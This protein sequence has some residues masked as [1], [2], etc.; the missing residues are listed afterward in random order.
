MPEQNRT[1]YSPFKEGK[2]FHIYNRANSS[3]DFL[4]YRSEN[5]TYFLKKYYEYLGSLLDTFAYCL[6][7]NHFHFM[8]RVGR[9]VNNKS[10]NTQDLITEQ[11]RRFFISYSQ[12]INKQESRRGSLFQKRFKRK[13]IDDSNYFTRLIFYIHNNPVHHGLVHNIEDYEWSSYL[14]ILSTGD[15]RLIR[16]EV[17]DWF[18]G[19]KEFIRY[20][21]NLNKSNIPYRYH[22]LE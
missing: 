15:T 22:H 3:S 13:L 6:I 19:R 7:P 1:Y 8:I 20:H 16:D 21:K 12:S 5:Y 4:F 14:A 17:L 11:F 2:F 9:R 10:E 18:G